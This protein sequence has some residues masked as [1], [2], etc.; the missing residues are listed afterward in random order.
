MIDWITACVEVPESWQDIDWAGRFGATIY[1]APGGEIKRVREEWAQLRG[2][3]DGGISVRRGSR[4]WWVSG[5]PIKY[6]SGQ[7]L[8][9]PSD[10]LYLLENCLCRVADALGLERAS[11]ARSGDLTR[12]DTTHNFQLGST[13]RVRE[14]LRI[15]AITARARYQ[16]AAATSHQTVYLGQH[17][18]RHKPSGLPADVQSA[19]EDA[20]SGLLRIE[21]TVRGQQMTKDGTR[22]VLAWEDGLLAEE[23][24]NRYWGAVELSS[25]CSLMPERVEGLSRGL[26]R[27]YELWLRGGD[28]YELLGRSQRYK[29]RRE[30]L[31]WSG[32]AVDIF[33]LR[34]SSVAA[35][36]ASED[37]GAYLRSLKPWVAEGRLAEW[38]DE[39]ANAA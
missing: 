33:V 23:Y 26:R 5:N 6:L 18:R 10:A 27:T 7:N 21:V 30:L 38:I 34:P 22:S 32:G 12:V 37:I 2:S 3:W 9:G 20:S 17:S 4:G 31:E 11:C 24:Y 28:C 15:A 16:G 13:E 39:T 8:S 25:G 36:I 19:V 29:A 1:L 35:D 14:I